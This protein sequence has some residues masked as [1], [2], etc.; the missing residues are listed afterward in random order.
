MWDHRFV[1][2]VAVGA[3]VCTEIFARGCILW[4]ERRGLLAPS[5]SSEKTLANSNI[6]PPFRNLWLKKVIGFDN[7]ERGG[8][9][10]SW[11]KIQ[12]EEGKIQ[13]QYVCT[14]V[15]V[16]GV[17]QLFTITITKWIQ[18]LKEVMIKKSKWIHIKCFWEGWILWKMNWRRNI[19]Y[20]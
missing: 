11:K 19:D 14:Y 7:R 1:L 9:A 16:G 15:C 18:N 3:E 12:R 20:S 4:N 10:I 8:S 5:S 2:T 17:I 6:F 13:T